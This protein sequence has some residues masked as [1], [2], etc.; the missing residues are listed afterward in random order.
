MA[1]VDHEA[2]KKK[3]GAAEVEKARRAWLYII[4][5]V[6]HIPMVNQMV[7]GSPS[8]TWSIFKKLYAPQADAETDKHGAT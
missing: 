7:T 8:E 3:F 4:L 1:S 2:L 6:Q 5:L